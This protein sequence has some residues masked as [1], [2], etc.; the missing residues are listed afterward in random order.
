MNTYYFHQIQFSNS[1]GTIRQLSYRDA[2]MRNFTPNRWNWSEKARKWVYVVQ[3]K[4]GKRSYAY[5]LE[6]PKEF[7]DLTMELKKIN[8]KLM[9]TEDPDENE[10]LF[11]ELMKIS[12]RMQAMRKGEI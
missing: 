1:N 8:D 9:G 2:L 4:N 12:D 3:N 7:I 5:Q 6:P 11:R 10:R